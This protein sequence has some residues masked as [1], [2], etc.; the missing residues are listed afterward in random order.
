MNE[1]VTYCNGCKCMTHSVRK[2]KL[3]FVC[4]KCGHDKTLSTLFQT[5][6]EVYL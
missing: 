1:D 2:G 3:M 6:V 4:G 5:E